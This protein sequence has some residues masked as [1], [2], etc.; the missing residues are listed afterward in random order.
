MPSGF[1]EGLKQALVEVIGGIIISVFLMAIRN[2]G[3]VPPSYISLFDLVNLVGSILLVIGMEYWGTG[4]LVGWLAGIWIM[5]Y[6]GLVEAWLV[7]LY[8]VVGL[9]ILVARFLKKG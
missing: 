8:F 7:I 2:S 3:L 5:H 9:T 1:E 6:S 4:Y